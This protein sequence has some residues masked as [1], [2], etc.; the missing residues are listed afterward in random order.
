MPANA[1]PKNYS[2]GWECVSGFRRDGDARIAVFV[3][4]NADATNRTYGA[5]RECLHGFQEVD[6]AACLEVDGDT[7][8]AI[9][10]GE[11]LSEW[12]QLGTTMDM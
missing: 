8:A 3:P 5:G 4:E 6:D 9:A 10:S 11:R 1:Q 12:V 2:E 7:C